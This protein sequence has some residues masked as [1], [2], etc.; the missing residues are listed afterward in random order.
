M[1]EHVCA[2]DC[3]Q[4]QSRSSLT[5]TGKILR[6]LPSVVMTQELIQIRGQTLKELEKVFFNFIYKE[7]HMR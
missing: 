7:D 5:Y 3:F 1:N 6:G 4:L 2:F